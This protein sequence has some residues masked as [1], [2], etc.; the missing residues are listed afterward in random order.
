MN[1]EFDK[2]HDTYNDMLEIVRNK[3]ILGVNYS[4]KNGCRTHRYREP[5]NEETVKRVYVMFCKYLFENKEYNQHAHLG[6]ENKN[7]IYKR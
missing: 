1:Q 4:F 5:L 3:Y 6:D 2:Y 7:N